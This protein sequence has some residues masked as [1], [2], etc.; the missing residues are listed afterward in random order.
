LSPLNN[1]N[2]NYSTNIKENNNKVF[3]SS[4]NDNLITSPSYNHLNTSSNNNNRS[5]YIERN[6]KVSPMNA[7]YPPVANI[8]TKKLTPNNNYGKIKKIVYQ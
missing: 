2:I 5:N 4:T 3:D 8:F 6:Y 1:N 7:I